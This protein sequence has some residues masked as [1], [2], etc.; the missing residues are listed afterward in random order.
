MFLVK[1]VE[2][3]LSSKK[4]SKENLNTCSVCGK[5]VNQIRIRKVIVNIS[6]FYFMTIILR[7]CVCACVW[8]AAISVVVWHLRLLF[9]ILWAPYYLGHS[10]I[11]TFSPQFCLRINLKSKLCFT[12]HPLKRERRV[13]V[14]LS[15]LLIH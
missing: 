11:H 7:V 12:Y 8:S 4:N 9:L 13:C 5:I 3:Y 2:F 15:R 14:K 6:P 10:P 1:K